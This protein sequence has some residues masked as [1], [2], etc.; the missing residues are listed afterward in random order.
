MEWCRWELSVASEGLRARIDNV[1][2]EERVTNVPH[3]NNDTVLKYEEALWFVKYNRVE[4]IAKIDMP[5]LHWLQ[6]LTWSY[7]CKRSSPGGVNQV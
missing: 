3:C 1:L 7:L 4:V 6:L 2:N 5:H